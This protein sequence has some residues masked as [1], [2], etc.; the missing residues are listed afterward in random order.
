MQLFWIVISF[1]WSPFELIHI[2]IKQEI[3]NI[4]YFITDKIYSNDER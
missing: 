2:L 4:G 3:S 1:M